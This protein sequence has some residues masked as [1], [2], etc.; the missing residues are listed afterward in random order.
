MNEDFDAV[1]LIGYGGPEKKEDII[2]FLK[3]VAQ[4]RPIPEERLQEVYHHYEIIGGRSP[5]NEYTY[6]QGEKL[7]SFLRQKGY[8]LPFFVAMRNWHPFTSDT[9]NEMSSKGLK[10]VVG[11]IMAIHQCDTSWERYQREVINSAEQ[12]GLDMEFVFT[13][14]LYDNPLFIEN[15]ADRVHECFNKIPKEELSDTK[16]IFTAHS[17]PLSMAD[18]SPYVEQFETSARLVAEKLGHPNWLTAYQSRSGAPSDP[19]LEPDVCDVISDLGNEGVKNIVVQAIGFLCD[20]VEVLFDIGVEAKEESERNG[21]NLFIAKTVNDDDK[22]IHA[23][24][25][26]V[27][28]TIDRS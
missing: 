13:E 4:G 5:L 26:A 3:K 23:L 1:M 18:S 7:E 27:I 9:L 22:F 2:P 14:P 17:I 20:H 15:C 6:R 19:W 21:I 28:K 12:Q 11:I 25:D 8:Q 10:R 16:L 24:E